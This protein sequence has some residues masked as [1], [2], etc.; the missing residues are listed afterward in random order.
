MLAFHSDAHSLALPP[1]HR[2]PQS[3]YRLLREYFERE[4]GLLRMQAAPAATE[5]ELALVHTPD[6][7][8]AVLLG[9]L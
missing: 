2:F 3:K 9:R 7:V 6:Y 8:D 4:P 5:G 1:G